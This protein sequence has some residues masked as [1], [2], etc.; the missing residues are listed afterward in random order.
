MNCQHPIT[1]RNPS[2]KKFRR[3]FLESHGRHATIEEE[4]KYLS[5][6]GMERTMQVPCGK[7]IYC[8][9]NRQDEWRTRLNIEMKY[10]FTAYFVTLTYAEEFC[11]YDV[12]KSDFQK[13][14]KRLRSYMSI[15]LRYFAISEYTPT[16]TQRP[17]FH[18]A[19]FFKTFVSLDELDVE[20]RKAWPLGFVTIGDLND[21]RIDYMSTYCIKYFNKPPAGHKPNFMLSSR[22]PCIGAEYLTDEMRDYHHNTKNGFVILNGYKH[23]LPRILKEKIFDDEEKIEL[24]EQAAEIVR[25]RDEKLKEKLKDFASPHEFY[26][27]K[28]RQAQLDFKFAYNRYRESKKF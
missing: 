13:F 23:K 9:Q 17:H 4:D 12:S 21:G 8:F 2:L 10:S 5:I 28:T 18:F 27:A 6:M 16:G 7:C 1:I 24:R 25:L 3:E 26:L 15:P 11:P 20:V 22:R 14:M 19:V